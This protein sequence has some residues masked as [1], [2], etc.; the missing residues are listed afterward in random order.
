MTTEKRFRAHLVRARISGW[1]L[2]S[3]L[4]P[5]RPDFIFPKNKVAVFVD[6]CFW[7]CCPQ[8]GHTPKSNR[9]YWSLKLARNRARDKRISREIKRLGWKVL[10]IWEHE[11]KLAPSHAVFK[12]QSAIQKD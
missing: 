11:I 6:G 4:L 10:R 12:L 9:S 5:G 8:C 1:K 2:Q 7:H 3:S